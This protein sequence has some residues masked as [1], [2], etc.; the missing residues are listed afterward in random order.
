MKSLK[1]ITSRYARLVEYHFDQ[2]VLQ[3]LPPEQRTMN[4]DVMFIP[5]MSAY[6]ILL[7]FVIDANRDR[8]TKPGQATPRVRACVGRL[9]TYAVTRVRPNSLHSDLAC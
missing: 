6:H 9:P 4:D 7:L 8:S 1:C 5:P 3:S 2:A